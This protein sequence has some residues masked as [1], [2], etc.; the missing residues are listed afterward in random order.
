MKMS[1]TKKTVSILK[2]K[3]TLFENQVE[4]LFESGKLE[5]VI[6]ESYKEQYSKLVNEENLASDNIMKTKKRR[7]MI[8][9][10]C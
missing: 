10:T 1:D 9:K 7:M 5:P 6:K 2:G 4:I 8:G 3:I